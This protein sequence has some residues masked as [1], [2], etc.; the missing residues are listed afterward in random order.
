MLRDARTV[1]IYAALLLAV[2]GG[3]GAVRLAGRPAA[4]AAKAPAGP[5]G[6]SIIALSLAAEEIIVGLDRGAERLAATT[7][8]ALDPRF[9]NIAREAAGVGRAVA[10][11][12][13]ERIVRLR[14]ELVIVAPYTDDAARSA[15]LRFG[16]RLLSLPDVDGVPAIREEIRT[17]GAAIG[18]RERAEALI[19]EM[20][21]R[22]AAARSR[23]PARA[24][25]PRVLRY[26]PDD[27]WV[28]GART[29]ID[30]AIRLAGGSNVAAENGVRGTRAVRKETVARWDPDVLIVE[31]EPAHRAAIVERLRAEPVL[32]SIS[33]LRGEARGLAVI[34]TRTLTAVSQHVADAVEA[35]VDALYGPGGAGG[36]AGTGD[37]G[38]AAGE[39]R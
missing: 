4:A 13:V 12:S 30:D 16:I 34:P 37:G 18:R 35:L 5:R 32:G 33:A 36:A 21:R 28:A 22:I 3:V 26:D 24:R 11:N 19:A 1:T 25:P 17:I 39:D 14:P 9:S 20:D 38:T 27:A 15:L 8:L 31:D 6:G 23:I 7:S 29:V 2:G 10:G